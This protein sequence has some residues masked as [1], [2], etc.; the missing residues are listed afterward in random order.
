MRIG[1]MVKIAKCALMP[2]VVGESAEIVDMQMQEFEKYTVYPLWVKMISGESKGKVYGFKYDEVEILPKAEVEI[3]PEAY[4]AEI[5]R[6]EGE[7]EVVKTKVIEQVKELL[8]RVTTAEEIL[9]GVT[10]AGRKEKEKAIKIGATVKIAKCAS[11]PEVV[12]VSGQIVGMQM[13]EFEKYTV[14]PLWVKVTSGA[15]KGK[16]Y[17]FRYDEV[18]ILSKAYR[19]QVTK[20]EGGT[21]IMKTKVV[22]QLEEILSGV[23]TGGR[24]EE[25][26]AIKVGAT[27][28]IGK[29]D[30]VPEVVGESAEIVGMQMQEFEKYTVYP[31]W[32]KI[33]S[34]E[35][36]GKIYGFRHDEVEVL[37]EVSPEKTTKMKVVEQLEEMLMT[38]RIGATVKIRG[39]ALMPEVVGESAEIV[40]MQVQEFEKYTAYPLWLQMTSGRRKGR[41]YG[42]KYD[43]VEILPKAYEAQITKQEGEV[44]VVKTKVIE[45]VEGLL[46]RVTTVE[47]IAEIEQALNEV[48]GRILLEPALGFWEGKT[49]CWEMFRCPET[50]RD[51]CPAFKYHTV[52]C[53]Q[54]EGTYCKLYDYGAK[55]DGTDICQVC[56]VYKRWG[57]DEPIAIKVRGKGFNATSEKVTK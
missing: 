42:F 12:G 13:Q 22:E 45:Q 14:Y 53:W 54:I 11:I 57:H 37:P 32:L 40:D 38:M 41:I 8:K 2:E 31:L 36:K 23:T 1:D 20:Q 15:H 30:S 52:P 39:C 7:V 44:E 17:G 55:G 18:E 6:K 46:K 9:G 47:D 27:V 34:G 51:E 48:K 33:T 19:A 29:C 49:P 28:K 25:E 21:E 35:R 4:E 43:E 24:E 5:T 50:I 56:R 16:I 10:T 3:L 26:K